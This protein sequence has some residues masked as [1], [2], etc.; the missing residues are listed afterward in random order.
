ME[1]GDIIGVLDIGSSK[2]CCLIAEQSVGGGKS[3]RE[4]QKPFEIIGI[5]HH[6]SRGVQSGCI[7]DLDDA[8]RSVKAAVAAAEA[9]AGRRLKSVFVG[10]SCGRLASYNFSASTELA[11]GIVRVEDLA[12]LAQ[13]AKEY[14]ERNGRGLVSL[15]EVHYALDANGHVHDPRGLAGRVLTAELHGVA[16]DKAALQN[17][18]VLLQRCFLGLRG[19]V[20]TAQ[21]SALAATTEEE[22]HAGVT[23]LDIGGGT[24]AA[25]IYESGRLVRI[26]VV[27]FGGAHVSLDIARELAI[28]FED[29]ERLKTR[30]GTLLTHSTDA[31]DIIGFEA[32]VGNQVDRRQV[33][34][35]QLR[36]LVEQRI[37]SILSMVANE[38]FKVRRNRQC[39]ARVVITG[40]SA[41]LLGLGEYA[42]NAL[43]R[44]VRV[45]GPASESSLPEIVASPGFSTVIGLLAAARPAN[46]LLLPLISGE[47]RLEDTFGTVGRWL[48]DSF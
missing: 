3:A 1:K 27:P 23:C 19:T 47:N 15:N 8:E 38:V 21:A 10:V 33:S 24:T 14:I 25:A 28:S 30:Y 32:M 4:Q 17:M 35:L 13:G 37:A 40:G 2:V 42:A 45:A 5:G 16:G 39:D 48:R 36:R 20:T 34:R 43:G 18:Q 12:T 7:V 26:A 22:R 9:Q 31:V 41:E 6:R 11:G 29:A 44:P 46:H